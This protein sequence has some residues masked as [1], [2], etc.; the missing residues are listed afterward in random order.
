MDII[1][2]YCFFF[3]CAKEKSTRKLKLKCLTSYLYS[4]VTA[5]VVDSLIT[6]LFT[7]S[8]TQN[9]N[10]VWKK[11]QSCPLPKHMRIGLTFDYFYPWPTCL[12]IERD[13]LPITSIEKKEEIWLGHMTKAPTF[14]EKKSKKQRYNTQ[15]AT[16]NF[17][18]TMITDQLRTVSWSNN[19]HSTGVVKP[20]YERS[21][22]LQVWIL[23]HKSAFESSFARGV[24]V[25]NTDMC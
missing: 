6:M 23:L 21:I 10:I 8:K 19:S 3:F 20:V 14:T 11:K 18:Y 5:N 4:S 12:N 16:K 17:D 25:P 13:H 15:N 24:G 2:L 9:Q 1:G 7:K 22:Y